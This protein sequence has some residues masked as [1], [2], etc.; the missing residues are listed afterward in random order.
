MTQDQ[1]NLKTMFDTAITFLDVHNSLWSGK[2]AFADAVTRVKAGLAAIE[3]KVSGQETPIEGITVD[4][5]TLRN[6]LEETLLE[7][8]NQLSAFA[9]K[10]GDNDLAAQ[11]EMTQAS[12]DKMEENDL[13]LTAGRVIDLANTNK[14]ILASDYD[15]PAA[16]IAKLTTRRADFSAKKTAPREAVVERSA[17]TTAIPTLIKNVRSIFRRELDKMMTPFKRTEPDFYSGYFA[18]RVVVDKAATQTP[19]TPPPPPV[20]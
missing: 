18:A 5:E 8:A 20:P 3:T 9:A 2:V 16:E 1:N 4:K 13:D 15:T 12:L 11:V 7:I 6:L 14:T 17:K 10:T 19:D